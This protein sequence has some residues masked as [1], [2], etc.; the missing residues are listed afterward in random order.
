M[1]WSSAIIL[2][3]TVVSHWLKS[4]LCSSWKFIAAY[5]NFK[6]A[7]CCRCRGL[8]RAIY[9]LS[10]EHLR[11][12]CL[13]RESN[14][15]PP[16]LQA[17]TLWKEPFE[18]PYLVAIRDLTCVATAPPQVTMGD[19]GWIRLRVTYAWRS[20]RMHVAAWELRI[21]SGSPLCRGLT[22]AIYI[23]SIE[24]L[25]MLCLSR[26]SNPGPPALQASTLWKE[27]FERPYLVAI[28]D[29]ARF[30]IFCT[31]TGDNDQYPSLNIWLQP[32]YFTAE[33]WKTAHWV[34]KH[35]KL[36]R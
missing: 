36:L 34:C 14:P 9:I 21:T 30:Y 1:T 28:R 13:S 15:G 3:K 11:M 20:D 8:T 16:A 29:L 7:N 22:R 26:E 6:M 27:P 32:E 33:N 18:R 31:L 25:R 10:I 2:R 19:R 35:N 17:S 24:H 5:S 23:L 12:L 4:P